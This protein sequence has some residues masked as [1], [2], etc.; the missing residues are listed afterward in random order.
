MLSHGCLFVIL[1]P[2]AWALVRVCRGRKTSPYKGWFSFF[3]SFSLCTSSP[4]KEHKTSRTTIVIIAIPITNPF[5][6]NSKK[7][8]NIDRYR[9]Q[10][11]SLFAS[12]FKIQEKLSVL[13]IFQIEKSGKFVIA[14]NL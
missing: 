8:A 7:N 4:I 13:C 2:L 10:N 9:P 14:I 11:F 1:F 3:F 6:D 12:S 5:K